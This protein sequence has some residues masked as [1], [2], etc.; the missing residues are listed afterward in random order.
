[1]LAYGAP[2]VA[3]AAIAIPIL[4]HMPKFYSDVILVPVGYIALAIALARG[5]DAITDPLMGWISDRTRS[6]WGR[7]RPWIALGTPLCAVA[8]IALFNPPA[9]LTPTTAGVWFGATFA[10]YF[11]FHTI[12]EIPYQGL[13]AELTP[14]HNERTRLFGLRALFLIAGTIIAAVLPGF[15]ESSDS[16]GDQ[17]RLLGNMAIGFAVALVVLFSILAATVREREEFARRAS[18]PLVPGVRR[19]LRNRPFTILL[20]AFVVGSLPSA[21]PAMLLPFFTDYVLKP[22]STGQA[23]ALFLALYFGAGFLFVPGWTW[24]GQRIGKLNAWLVSM[25]IGISVGPLFFLAGEGDV[26]WVAGLHLW[27][28]IAFGAGFLLVPSMQADVIDYDEL[29]TGKR[30][31]AQYASFWAIVPKFVAIPG[32]ALPI[33]ALAAMGYLPNVEQ[34]PQVLLG[35]RVLYCLVPMSFGVITLFLVW[36][37]P[38]SEAVHAKIQEGIAAH[39]RGEDAVDP[40]TGKVVS[41]PTGRVDEETGWFLDHFSPRELARVA[42]GGAGS[43]TGIVL[44]KAGACLVLSVSALWLGIG[45]LQSL[46]VQPGL[47]AVLCVVGGG[48]AAT[49][50]AFHLARWAAARRMAAAPTDGDVVR[51]HLKTLA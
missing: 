37:Y 17:R 26:A 5:L 22:E 7:R 1:M 25:L 14:D 43:L 23:V 2:T 12:Y 50:V 46:H 27:A 44:A 15:L 39:E 35:I 36:R 29:H 6:R 13:G 24:L 47:T 40:L 48:F 8:L 4:V 21:M 9:S 10:L 34:P 51:A 11:L 33:A 28:G 49:G 18:N 32:A 45:S 19:A 20:I 16:A 38:I 31:E 3:G 42:R 30:R 41:P